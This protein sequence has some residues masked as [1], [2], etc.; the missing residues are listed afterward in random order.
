MTKCS[1]GLSSRTRG[2]SENSHKK[3]HI[4]LFVFICR[5]AHLWVFLNFC[6]KWKIPRQLDVSCSNLRVKSNILI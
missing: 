2:P 5:K 6:L 4:S 1:N 3:S